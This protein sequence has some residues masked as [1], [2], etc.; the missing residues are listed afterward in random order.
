MWIR[1][2]VVEACRRFQGS[3]SSLEL[4]GGNHEHVYSYQRDGKIYILKLYSIAAKDPRLIEIELNWMNYLRENGLDIPRPVTSKNNHF[5]EMIAMLPLP[6]SAVSFEQLEGEPFNLTKR[7]SWQD[8]FF[9]QFGQVMGKIHRLS[10]EFSTSCQDLDE[11]DEGEIYHRDFSPVSR[12]ELK[13]W[14]QLKARIRTFPK[15]PESYGL[16]I[17]DLRIGSCLLS[18]Q[19]HFA[20]YDMTRIKRHWYTYDIAIALHEVRE[21][22][23]P[24]E[25]EDLFTRFLLAFIEGYRQENQL[26]S[27]QYEQIE[28]FIEFR[29][30]FKELQRWI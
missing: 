27:D 8:R 23:Q 29:R 13:K 17:N 4:I 20:I 6:F 22:L 5:I 19:E 25:Y 16:I 12:G 1:E 30:L 28:F 18:R 9:R 11:W 21:L 15:N 3:T 7:S 14:E 2:N 10:Q 24:S 26:D